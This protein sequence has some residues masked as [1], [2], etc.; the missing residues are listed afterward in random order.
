MVYYHI[1][2]ELDVDGD[3][4][5]K[6]LR[7]VIPR[8]LR[9]T[10]MERIHCGNTDIAWSLQRARMSI[11]WQTSRITSGHAKHAIVFG[12]ELSTRKGFYSMKDQTDHGVK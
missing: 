7:C 8:S 10:I 5:L 2:D 3:V 4:I 1:R 11:F 9:Q 12:K 6:G